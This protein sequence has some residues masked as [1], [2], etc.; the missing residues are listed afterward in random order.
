MSKKLTVDDAIYKI[1]EKCKSLNYNFIKFES[2]WID[3]KSTRLIIKCNIHQYEFNVSFNNFIYN[4]LKCSKCTGHYRK[5]KE[6]ALK[7]I[8]NKCEKDK[9]ELLSLDNWK[10]N[11]TKLTVKC[12]K[13]DYIWKTNYK[14]FIYLNNSCPKCTKNVLTKKEIYENI[15]KIS[16]ENNYKFEIL[17]YDGSKTKIKI[18]CDKNHTYDFS[19]HSY[20]YNQNKCPKCSN[21]LPLSEEEVINNIS[22]RCS[23]T[24]YKFIKFINLDGSKSRFILECMIDNHQWEISYPNFIYHLKGCPKCNNKT[25]FAKPFKE[26]ILDK[27]FNNI[28]QE[29]SFPNLKNI[30]KLNYD[31]YIEKYKILIELNGPE[32]YHK[33]YKLQKNY[34]IKV[35]YAK[36]NG[37][38]LIEI[39]N[40]KYLDMEYFLNKFSKI[41]KK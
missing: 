35:Q 8:K 34:N 33:N 21:S 41:I 39:P 1:N 14:Y 28:V 26:Q 7:L 22:K 23:E 25:K 36:E 31:F 27:I 2:E 40:K 30:K 4:N 17:K 15:E 19:Y 18:I 3:A 29:K 12:L 24:N 9:F 38:H 32:H 13:D 16:L 10:G 37:F 20:V 5:T 11:Y 6:E